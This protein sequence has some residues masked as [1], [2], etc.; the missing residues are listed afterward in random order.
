M[1]RIKLAVAGVMAA[2]A[3]TASAAVPASAA[4]ARTATSSIVSI[5]PGETFFEGHIC[6]PNHTHN[7]PSD[8]CWRA[9]RVTFHGAHI[10]VMFMTPGTNPAKS[11]G[12]IFRV[13]YVGTVVDRW[14][15][16]FISY[17]AHWHGWKVFNFELMLNGKLTGQCAQ[18]GPGTENQGMRLGNCSPTGQDSS[19]KWWSHLVWKPSSYMIEPN[20]TNRSRD[21]KVTYCVTGVFDPNVPKQYAWAPTNV[22]SCF[23]HNLTRVTAWWARR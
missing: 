20:L 10:Y 8:I 18:D 22:D 13:I 7:G 2:A 3:V 5:R 16:K 14:P 9:K 15:F 1:K 17:N 21:S 23:N 11:G 19:D 4:P 12:T 6:L